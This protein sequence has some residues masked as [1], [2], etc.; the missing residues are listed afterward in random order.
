[1]AAAPDNRRHTLRLAGLGVL[2]VVA[3]GGLLWFGYWTLQG[4]SDADLPVV[5]APEGD[6]KVAP[7]DRGGLEVDHQDASIYEALVR[8]R[9]GAVPETIGPLPEAPRPV[10]PPPTPA[11]PPEPAE[12]GPKAAP[13]PVPAP[14]GG[15]A[16][17]AAPPAPPTPP[18]RPQQEAAAPLVVQLG[19]FG[20]EAAARE[21]WEGL[22]KRHD[23]L[24][25]RMEAQFVHGEGVVRVRAGPVS[26]AALAQLVCEQLKAR[27]VDCF[28]V[29]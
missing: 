24:L 9:P 13:M 7:K 20:T 18:A 4:S 8:G 28:L 11:P 16:T 10:I 1:M 3:V 12:T 17:A 23:D 5:K 29:R 21:A 6:Y 26:N 14:R 19:A 27:D 25:G 15:S 22:K 2:S